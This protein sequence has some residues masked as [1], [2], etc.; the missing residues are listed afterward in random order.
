ML[1][2]LKSYL[3]TLKRKIVSMASTGLEKGFS[4][5]FAQDPKCTYEKKGGGRVGDG[6]GMGDRVSGEW[7][8][9]NTLK[10]GGTTSKGVHY[11]EVEIATKKKTHV[12]KIWKQVGAAA[13]DYVETI[14]DTL[15]SAVG[16]FDDPL[17]T[18]L[19]RV[20]NMTNR[21]ITNT[22]VD[23]MQDEESTSNFNQ[24]KMQHAS[25][26]FIPQSVWK[27]DKRTCRGKLVCENATEKAR[28]KPCRLIWDVWTR[29]SDSSIMIRSTYVKNCHYVWKCKVSEGCNTWP[30]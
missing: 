13:R 30:G 12:L 23:H 7:E 22:A 21:T 10:Y 3:C 8:K 27:E 5:V 25:C 16:Y 24:V 6:Q 29:C 20:K 11:T 18:I 14:K 9:L 28:R 1:Y 2:P 19:Q 17:V 4:N 26:G 15:S